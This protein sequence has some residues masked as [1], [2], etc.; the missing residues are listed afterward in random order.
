MKRYVVVDGMGLPRYTMIPSVPSDDFDG[1]RVQDGIVR[2]YVGAESDGYLLDSL[3]WVGGWKV[4]PT[5]PSPH[6]DWDAELEQWVGNLDH[7]LAARKHEINAERERRNF[8]PIAYA[9]SLFD[10]NATALRNIA[11]WQTQLAAGAVL[12]EGF[13]WRDADNVDHPADAAFL[14][15]LGAAITLRGTALYQ[16]AWAHKAALSALTDIDAILAYDL[17]ANWPA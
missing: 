15:G 10:A 8:L 16:A 9:G 11:G 6:H 17:A 12:P 1:S 3:Y 13:V 7:A 4:R 2:E 5:K 14:N